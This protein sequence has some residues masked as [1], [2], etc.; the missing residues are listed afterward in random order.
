MTR[1][2]VVRSVTVA[3][4]ALAAFTLAPRMT[5][6]A[7]GVSLSLFAAAEAQFLDNMLAK[8]RGE[9][10]PP[11]IVSS[12]GR[13]EA[14][15]VNVSSKYPGRLATVTVAEGD[16]V[17]QGQTVAT[18]T[19]P[20]LDAQLKAA[21]ADEQRAKDAEAAA[22]ASISTR[23]SAADFAKAEYERGAALFKTGTITKQSYE[24]RK[25][26]MEAS[27]SELVAA[28]SARDQARSAIKNAEAQVERINAI[29]ADL[30]LVSPRNGR[31]QYELKRA[32]EVV[33]GGT[34]VLTILDLTDVYMTI[35]VP[36]NE[37]GKLAIGGEAR[38]VLDPVPQYVIPATVSF[39]ASD[40]QFTPKTVET[41]DERQ[42]L[43]FRV[44]L[45]IDPTVLQTFF[46]RV[47]TGV[48]GLG[49]VRTDPS[50]AWPADLQTKLPAQ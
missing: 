12:N 13:I 31:V 9:R 49:Y 46:T 30:N 4:V 11:G 32:G 29:L 40:A 3:A 14:T 20:E 22:E 7:N 44:K 23:Q 47:K 48:R 38:L 10:F 41:K 35:F 36:A 33:S 8:L 34:P 19:S 27:Q 1:A 28:T 24:Q 21:Q 18:V 5:P 37:A 39:V 43:M 16:A 50:V 2:T 26:N 45:K 25:R 42:K 17:T 6:S 15:Q